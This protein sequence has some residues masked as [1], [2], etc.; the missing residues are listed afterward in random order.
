MLI[1]F[2]SPTLQRVYYPD[3]HASLVCYQYA[4]F[5]FPQLVLSVLVGVCV[6]CMVRVTMCRS[7]RVDFCIALHPS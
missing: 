7:E 2:E 6:N 3:M 1:G 5:P 4:V